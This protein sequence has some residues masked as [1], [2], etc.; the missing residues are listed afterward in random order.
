MKMPGVALVGTLAALLVAAAATAEELRIG[1]ASEPSSID[2]HYHGLAT[3]EAMR[4]HIFEALIGRD[5]KQRPVPEL[6]QSWQAIDD[7]TWEFKLRK[8]VKFHDGFEF[9]ARDFVYTVCRVPNVPNSPSPYAIHT[10][11]IEDIDVPDPHT[12]VIKTARPLPLL[13]VE[14]SRIGIVSAQAAGITG[15]VTFKKEGCTGITDWPKPEDFDSGKLAVGTGPYKLAEF[16][17]GKRIVLQK[18]PDYWGADPGWERVLFRPIEDPAARVAALLAGEV[19]LIEDPPLE[20]LARLQE[21]PAIEIVKDLSNRVI[22]LNF[23]HFQEP[24]PGVKGS[25]GKNPFKDQR[26]R[27]AVSKAIDRRAIVARVMGGAAAPAGQ[28]LPPGMFGHNPDLKV[29][30][31]DPEG[32]KELL[33]AAG[34]GKGFELVI[35]TPNDRY[36][37]DQEVTQAVAEM[38]TRVGIK[39]SVEAATKSVFLKRRN[40]YGFSL[41]LSGWRS[42]I[43]EMSSPLQ[44]LV[45]SQDKEKGFG[46][47]NRGRYANPKLDALLEEALGTIDEAARSD[48]L[49]RA[50]K[51]VIKDYGIL[52]L[53]F[54]LATWAYRKGIT[55]E[56]RA[57]RQTLATGV[58]KTN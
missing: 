13:P 5:A 2:P 12:V 50:S 57:D 34:Y 29:E 55:G 47:S 1:I 26:V 46:G 18:N 43:G 41:Y 52:P 21:N 32:A 16:V 35:G 48:V 56:A 39:T 53:Y 45:A 11:G 27:H 3:N 42:A 38:L 31:Y 17:K 14:L 49:M 22:Y 30:P 4:R 15:N 28:L 7:T 9:S 24:T 23:D 54:E 20:E 44:A 6:A 25:G 33:A 40:N 58:R 36:A 8:G 37:M 51:V 19:D 10:R